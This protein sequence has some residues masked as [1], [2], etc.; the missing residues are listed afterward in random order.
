MHVVSSPLAS[1]N[2][3]LG[4][5]I[6]RLLRDFLSDDFL[7]T[8]ALVVHTE[9]EEL[10]EVKVVLHEEPNVAGLEL[11]SLIAKDFRVRPNIGIE[12]TRSVS[13][14]SGIPLEATHA[15]LESVHAS[16]VVPQLLVAILCL[17][18]SIGF[19]FEAD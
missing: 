18:K 15:N 17:V 6:L 19:V 2:L 16:T 12:G 10:V 13:C 14:P 3:Y 5:W 8:E 11:H 9:G 1:L 7:I 4:S